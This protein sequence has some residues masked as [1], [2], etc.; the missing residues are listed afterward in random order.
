MPPRT[1]S[2]AATGEAMLIGG[3]FIV[4]QRNEAEL[5]EG[6]CFFECMIFTKNGLL[7]MLSVHKL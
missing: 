5:Q 4:R 6:G 1:G 2:S 3:R 7:R